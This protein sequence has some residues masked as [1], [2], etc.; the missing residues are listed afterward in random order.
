MEN[1]ETGWKDF[2]VT[3]KN[4]NIFESS[5]ANILLS[6]DTQIGIGIDNRE[7]KKTEAAL[8]EAHDSLESKVRKR[9]A[10]LERTLNCP[11]ERNTSP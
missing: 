3:A 2:N 7:R 1:L 9:T 8:R 6:D 10:E 11:A 4:G 5:W